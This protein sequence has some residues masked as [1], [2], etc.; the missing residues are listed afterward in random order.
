VP[1]AS[2][3]AGG[4]STTATDDRRI[5]FVLGIL[6]AIL[7]LIAAVLH[8]VVGVALLVT[9]AAHSGAGS[10][11]SSVIEVVVALLIGF[12]ALLGRGRG[13]DRNVA[14][15]VVLIVLA[16]VGWAALGFG[17]DLLALLAAV[18]ALVSGVL[19]LV[20]GR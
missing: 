3:G 5:A 16:V 2:R 10:I 20:A 4:I 8:F 15:G 19:F 12:F 6:A 18:L 1:S 14:A 7:L 11:G 13:N 9:G 17:G